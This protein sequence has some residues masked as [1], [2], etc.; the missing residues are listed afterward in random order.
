MI[1]DN[2]YFGN[3]KS[4]MGGAIYL[5][6]SEENK[7]NY[8]SDIT[9]KYIIRKSI[10]ENIDSYVGGALY[11]DHPQTMIISDST[12]TKLRAMNRSSE[13]KTDLP[14]GIAGAIYYGCD[15]NDPKCSLTIEGYTLFS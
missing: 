5:T 3:L 14:S 12:F 11:L 8:G 2:S 13:K 15:S 7:R 4:Q 6:D 1:I 10:F 9:D